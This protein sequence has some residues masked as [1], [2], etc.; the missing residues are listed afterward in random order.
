MG[1]PKRNVIA[2]ADETSTPPSSLTNTQSIARV[3]KAEGNSLYTCSL[4]NDKTVLVELPSRFR[5]AIWMK[6]GGYVLVDT[7]DA[8]IRQNKIGGEIINVVRDEHK[9]RKQPYWPK[10]YP[11]TAVYVDSDEE[12]STV[13]KMPPSDDSEDE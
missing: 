4:P 12:E 1:R 10:E 8:D 13:G 7:K 9:W 6:R 2:A 11:K 5:N 3:V